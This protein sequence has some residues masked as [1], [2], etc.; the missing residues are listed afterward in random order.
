MVET[1]ESSQD[2]FSG[3]TVYVK[4]RQKS[5]AVKIRIPK[6]AIHNNRIFVKNHQFKLEL[7]FKQ[8][9]PEEEFYEIEFERKYKFVRFNFIKNSPSYNEISKPNYSGSIILFARFYID[10]ERRASKPKIK[11]EA[12]KMVGLRSTGPSGQKGMNGSKYTNYEYNNAH[13]PFEG[14]LVQP[15]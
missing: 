9:A 10:D 3:V 12:G 2:L 8:I 15:K 14:G 4:R 11:K 1:T 6:T 7:T 5:Y 13:H